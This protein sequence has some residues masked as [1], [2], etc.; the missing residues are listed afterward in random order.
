M[1]RQALPAEVGRRRPAQLH[2]GIMT[3]DTAQATIALDRAPAHLHLFWV[4]KRFDDIR[5]QGYGS[6]KDGNDVSERRSRP[7]VHVRVLPGCRTRASPPKCHWMHTSSRTC[8]GRRAGLT[9][10]KSIGPR[11]GAFSRRSRTWSSHGP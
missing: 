8:C 7:E 3:R 5:V 2:V 9:I 11:S 1:A 10:E 4:T 6:S